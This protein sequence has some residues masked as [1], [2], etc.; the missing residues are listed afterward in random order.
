MID[1]HQ[2]LWYLKKSLNYR[3]CVQQWG[4]SEEVETK[5]QRIEENK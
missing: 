4:F 5:A 2:V 1:T 3:S